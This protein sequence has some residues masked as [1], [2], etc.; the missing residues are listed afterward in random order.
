MQNGANDGVALVNAAGQVVDF[1]S[2]EGQIKAGNGPAA[3]K[4]S[5]NLP[6]S[7]SNGTPV[8]TSLPRWQRTTARMFPWMRSIG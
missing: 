8:G 5:R 4:T 7:E 1:I 6:V 2:Y 3:G